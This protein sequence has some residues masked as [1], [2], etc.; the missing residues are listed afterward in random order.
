[1]R[2]WLF[3]ER[4][5]GALVD[6]WSGVH[7]M[8]GVALGWVVDPF[9]ALLVMV[10]WEPFEVLV[11]SPIAQRIWG[12]EFGFESMRNIMSDIVFDAMGVA[13][14]FWLLRWLVAPPFILF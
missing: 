1:M 7:L 6:V 10:L 13:L 5:N 14:G 4:R 11:L 9:V 2:N 8:T 3:D 12:A